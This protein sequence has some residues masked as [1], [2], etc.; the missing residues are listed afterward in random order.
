MFCYSAPGKYPYSSDN[1]ML[2]LRSLYFLTCLTTYASAFTY[3]LQQG[4]TGDANIFA[5]GRNSTSGLG[6]GSLPTEIPLVPGYSRNMKVGSVTGTTTNTVSS[7]T[8]GPDGF[9]FNVNI[10]PVGGISGLYAGRAMALLGVFVGDG[11]PVGPAPPSIDFTSGTGIGRNFFSLA[12]AIGQ[13]FLI[14]DGWASV[15]EQQVFYIP[16]AATRLFIGF[17]DAGGFQGNPSNFFD[18]GGFLSGTFSFTIPVPVPEPAAPV[19][20]GMGALVALGRRRR[21]G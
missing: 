4:A 12:P 3:S 6:G 18:N 15:S 8:W 11:E 5:A 7:S 19:M 14:G 10:N 2:V 1:I 17:A 16:E 20:A 9:S 13:V 21:A